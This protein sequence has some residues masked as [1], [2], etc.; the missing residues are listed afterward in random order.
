MRRSDDGISYFVNRSHH[1]QAM[2]RVGGYQFNKY[3][4]QRVLNFSAWMANP[5][6]QL[7][8]YREPREPGKPFEIGI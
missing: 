1:P 8:E 7:A 3:R 2:L 4:A 5:R 6:D